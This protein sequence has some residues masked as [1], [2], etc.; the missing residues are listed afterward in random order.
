MGFRTK[1]ALILPAYAGAVWAATAAGMGGSDEL[2][3][4]AVVLGV[5]GCLVVVQALWMGERPVWIVVRW[6]L[7]ILTVLGAALGALSRGEIAA[8]IVAG[9]FI[10]IASGFAAWWLGGG[11]FFRPRPTVF[12]SYRRQ[13]SSQACGQL[14]QALVQE[15]GR[16]HV[17]RD[18]DSIPLGRDFKEEISR[19]VSRCQVV[20]ALIGTEW[21]N[22]RDARGARRL[23]QPGD[24]VRLEIETAL[25]SGVPVVPV[26]VG[27]AAPPDEGQLPASLSSLSRMHGVKLRGGTEFKN[28]AAFLIRRIR[29]LFEEHHG[30][31]FA[32]EA[33]AARF[34][35]R[36]KAGLTAA[37]FAIFVAPLLLMWLGAVTASSRRLNDAALS[38]D[39]NHIA[40]VYGQGI[41]VRGNVRVWNARTGESVARLNAPG[42]PF[43]VIRWSPDGAWIAVGTHHGEV[44]LWR[45]PLTEERKTLSGPQGVLQAME[46]APRGGRL[47]AGDDLGRIWVWDVA[48]GKRLFSKPLFH[49]KVSALGWSPV[50]QRLAGGSWD[51]SVAL[52]DTDEAAR[53]VPLDLNASYV[54]DLAWSADGA[55][56]AVTTLKDPFLFVF[57][58]EPGAGLTQSLPVRARDGVKSLAWSPAGSLLAVTYG[59]RVEVWDAAAL[60]DPQNDQPQH[61]YEARAFTGSPAS[62]WSPD[63]KL[64]A[65]AEDSQVKV[66]D[67]DNDQA[68]GTHPTERAEIVGWM[69][70]GQQYVTRNHALRVWALGSPS[71]LTEM[72]TTVWESIWL[73][74]F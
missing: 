46:W 17:F 52:L 13:D 64:L 2:G 3:L 9:L 62:S 26:F 55:Y 12:L 65:V 15:L 69:P 5:A 57:R 11:S 23:D 19:V 59:D 68:V 16:R 38:P 32:T 45:W 66:W 35:S 47:A 20:L 4:A 42:A 33:A 53:P 24:F 22:I 51:E 18:I 70:G 27:D 14:Y 1:L 48:T 31:V 28:D 71:P 54:D 39:G 49:E 61:I 8:G 40:A 7:S 6:N 34:S 60:A 41:D 10:G 21:L 74:F 56:L 25:E 50:A 63:G 44:H 29:E 58:I 30:E 36:L 37:T 72:K 73:Q 67:V 43:W